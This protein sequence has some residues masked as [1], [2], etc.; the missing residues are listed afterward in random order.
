MM[1]RAHAQQT[2]IL[3][4]VLPSWCSH[5]AN[6]QNE[7]EGDLIAV[8]YNTMNI[9]YYGKM[10]SQDSKKVTSTNGI[11]KN[12]PG[13]HNCSCTLHHSIKKPH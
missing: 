1:L 2:T 10:R 4:C 5:L 6:M 7:S 8:A 11:C 12:L 13:K 9:Y 3:F